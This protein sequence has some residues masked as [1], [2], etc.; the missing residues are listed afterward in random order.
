MQ[1]NMQPVE[2]DTE[3]HGKE[4]ALNFYTDVVYID[5]MRDG[6]D[7]GGRMTRKRTL[8]DLR[9]IAK[10]RV[11]DWWGRCFDQ[12][13]FMYLSG[14]RGTDTSDGWL[15]PVSYP[16]FANNSLTA[17]DTAH[18]VGGGQCTASSAMQAT[19]TMSTLPIDRGVAYAEMMGGG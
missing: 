12:I 2:G 3:L 19:D 11:T 14:A 18:L 5:Q 1:L 4:E 10:A 9:K 13:I 7:C 8:H 6:V 15:F 17:P 16:G